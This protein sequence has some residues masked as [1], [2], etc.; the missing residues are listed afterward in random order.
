M[1][2][3]PSQRWKKNPKISLDEDNSG[4]QGLTSQKKGK[5]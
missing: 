5:T 1:N 3:M 4:F 2:D